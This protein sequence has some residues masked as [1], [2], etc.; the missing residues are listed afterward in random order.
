MIINQG[1]FKGKIV[2]KLRKQISALI[3]EKKN[4]YISKG[5]LNDFHEI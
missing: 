5:K 2:I 4:I 1:E 3:V